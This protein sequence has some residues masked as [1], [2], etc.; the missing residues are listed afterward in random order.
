VDS[1]I[2]AS[3]SFLFFSYLHFSHFLLTFKCDR[4]VG[5]AFILFLSFLIPSI[6]AP[7][8]L[9]VRKHNSSPGLILLGSGVYQS[10]AISSRDSTSPDEPF[11][12]R[13][14]TARWFQ[15]VTRT[16]IFW[17]SFVLLSY[18]M[19]M[20]SFLPSKLW[21]LTLYIRTRKNMAI[22]FVYNA[23]LCFMHGNILRIPREVQTGHRPTVSPERPKCFSIFCLPSGGIQ[24]NVSGSS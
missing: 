15:R 16:G 18:Q 13:S 7:C 12:F 20:T 4:K 19:A 2:I 3:S 17:A 8:F 5:A 23:E 21:L 1:I 9:S 11:F 6:R 22:S 14:Q 24:R 10:C